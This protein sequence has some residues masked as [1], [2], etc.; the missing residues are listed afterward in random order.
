MHTAPPAPAPRPPQ[1]FCA[2]YSVAMA[3]M[4]VFLALLARGYDYTADTNTPWV[5]EVGRVP[6]N[7]LPLTVTR[8][9]A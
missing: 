5:Q 3:E 2:G 8:L 6:K 1:R 7:G 9:E 4:K